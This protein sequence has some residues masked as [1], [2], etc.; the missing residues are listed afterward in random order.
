MRDPYVERLMSR[1]VETVAPG[2]TLREA[3]AAMLEHDVGALVVLDSANR[4]EGLLTTTSFV[5]AVEG[6]VSPDTAVA[7][8]MQ[9]ELVTVGR[10]DPLSEAAATM[11]DH[12]VHH[13]PV[14]EGDDVVGVLSTQ[15]VT[16]YL[17]RFLEP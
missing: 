4:L 12:R 6:D 8:R 5:Q 2:A 7:E 3:A 17:V 1:P 10:R 14:V 11:L 9:R 15:D 16:A 13:V